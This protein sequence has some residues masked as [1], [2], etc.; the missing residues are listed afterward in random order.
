LNLLLIPGLEKKMKGK[1]R[2]KINDTPTTAL[3]D[4]SDI[5]VYQK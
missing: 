5:V 1:E 4:V 2:Q 3:K